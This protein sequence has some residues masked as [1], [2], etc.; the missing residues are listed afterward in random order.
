MRH[1]LTALGCSLLASGCA[2]TLSTLQ[3][4]RTVPPKH[5]QMQ[6]GYGYYVPAQT[7]VKIVGQGVSLAK[8]GFDAQS[9]NQPYELTKDEVQALITSG[10]SLAVFPP[11]SSYETS[12]RTGLMKNWD[13]GFKYS[14]NALRLDTK[15]RLLHVGDRESAPP[16]GTMA[17]APR[18]IGAV[19]PEVAA[20][21]EPRLEPVQPPMKWPA[22]THRSFDVAVGL[23]GSRYL[24][25]SKVFEVLDYVQIN[26][27]SRW[28][29][30]V[31]L[32]FSAEF[33]EVFKLYGA[34]KY[35]FSRTT[36]D[37]KL[38]GIFQ[39]ASERAGYD[40]SL[41]SKVDMHFFGGTVGV[42]LGYR[43]V[44][45][46][47]E[48]TGGYTLCRPVVFGQERDLGGVTLYPA[49]AIQVRI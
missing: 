13:V 40:F 34:S 21:D 36:M 4:A 46:L 43:W 20:A 3:T 17:L 15:Y 49:G 16:P 26:D 10:T 35:L 11:S 25:A 7:A 44:H 24:F 2:T 6:Y 29:V 38:V 32:Y 45:F 9:N 39:E 48:I 41:P 18:P 23:A 8:K 37:A 5:V 28:D 1:A 42:A 30:E 33:G 27:F 19:P 31:P 47:L 14:G 22:G 12:V